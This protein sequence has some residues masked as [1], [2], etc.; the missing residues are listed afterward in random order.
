VTSTLVHEQLGVD[1]KYLKPIEFNSPFVIESRGK[2]VTITLFHANHCPGAAMFL[3]EVGGKKI[4]HVGDF[5]W[6]QHL[7]MKIPQ[8]RSFC[9]LDN[10]LDEIFLDTTYCDP[11]YRFPSQES[12]ISKT[13]QVVEKEVALTGKENILFLFGSYTIGKEKV[14]MSIAKHLG[15]KVYVDSRRYRILSALQWPPTDMR[16][17]TTS[18]SEASMLV[19]PMGHL[20]FKKMK[21]YGSSFSSTKALSSGFKRIIGFRPTGWSYSAEANLITRRDNGTNTI[22]SGERSI[23]SLITLHLFHHRFWKSN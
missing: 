8:L 21:E 5:R 10:R 14:Y 12:V 15:M 18:K 1:R 3:F 22:F 9:N 19:V 17:L 11:K 2:P 7:M 16:L 13:I 20:N 23:K 6:N 4:L